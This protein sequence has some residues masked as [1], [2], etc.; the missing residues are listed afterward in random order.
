MKAAMTLILALGFAGQSWAQSGDKIDIQNLEK[1]YWS[2]KDDDFSVIQNRKYAKAKRFH[3][4]M[5]FGSLIN[6]PFATGYITS[7]QL[8][9]YFNERWGVDLTY[10]QGDMRLNDSAKQ[11][12]SQYGVL[13]TFGYYRDSVIASANFVPLYAKMSWLDSSIIYFDMGVSLGV[14]T[15][16]YD[17]QREEGS[18]TKTTPVVS[19]GI[20]Q[21]IFFSEHWAVKVE[22]LNKFSSQQ[23]IRYESSNPNRDR[24]NKTINDTTLHIGLTYWH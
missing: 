23:Q 21:Q 14:G 17:I 10:S 11:F 12:E 5:G 20:H 15:L 1:K 7:A 3:L 16:T 22:L 2:A 6:D 8:G 24:G 9:Y 13:P 19:A 18:L 4:T